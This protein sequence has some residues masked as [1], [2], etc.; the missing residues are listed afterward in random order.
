MVKLCCDLTVFQAMDYLYDGE[1]WGIWPGDVI[2]NEKKRSLHLPAVLKD[3]L[4]SYQYFPICKGP[5]YFL[6]PDDMQLVTS[7]LWAEED[8]AE[9]SDLRYLLIGRETA[10][11][12]FIALPL[13]SLSDENPPVV[14]AFFSEEQG[15][16]WKYAGENLA[17]F[18][19]RMLCINLLAQRPYQVVKEQEQLAQLLAEYEVTA[20]DL[21]PAMF[22]YPV[23]DQYLSIGWD[24]ER[25]RFVLADMTLEGTIKALLL[26]P[27]AESVEADTYSAVSTAE[28]EQLL[29]DELYGKGVDSDDQRVLELAVALINRLEQAEDTDAVTLGQYYQV[30]GR[31][32]WTLKN[33][34][35]AH[36]W[37]AKAS[38][39]LLPLT[40]EQPQ[41]ICQLYIS[42]ANFYIDAGEPENGWQAVGRAQKICQQFLAEDHRMLGSVLQL[43]GQIYGEK[44]G[45]WDEAI[46]L[47]EQAIEVYQRDAKNNQYDIARCQQIKGDMRRRK[48]AAAQVKDVSDITY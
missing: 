44:L 19:K 45:R 35:Q 22:S 39:Y 20:T 3:F 48:K 23:I 7:D 42:L 21:R 13:E 15:I 4:L 47:L 37:Y 16:F 31:C 26:I 5:S 28:L 14:L 41:L 8:A 12:F 32:C 40:E 25:Q 2:K 46:T 9:Q 34:D 1:K 11:A 18:A 17:E 33:W 6:H 27:K 38:S 43:Q 36:F 30:A 29:A 10:G 24:E